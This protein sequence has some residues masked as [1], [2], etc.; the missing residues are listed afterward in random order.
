MPSSSYYDVDAI[1][2]QEELIPCVNC[3]DFS[4]LAH[5]S[6]FPSNKHFLEEGTQIKMPHWAIERW[7][8]LGFCR[9]ALPK[10][11]NRKSRERLEADPAQADLRYVCMKEYYYL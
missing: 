3:F 1:L 2:A 8:T 7:A 9:I 11:F 4:R 6:S 5:L 10:H